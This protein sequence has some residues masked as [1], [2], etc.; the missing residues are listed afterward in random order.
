MK[1]KMYSLKERFKV[2]V[3]DTILVNGYVDR[4]DNVPEIDPGY[5][6][7]PNVLRDIY[8]WWVSGTNDGFFVF[9]PHGC[10]KT[11]ALTQFFARLNVPVYEKTLY[12]KLRF[13]DLV[14]SFQLVNGNTILYYGPLCKAMGVED[15][16]GVFLMNECD[17][18]N[19]GVLTGM[20][21]IMQGGPLDVLGHETLKPMPGFRIA[22]TANTGMLL[23]DTSGVYPG[24]KRQS[25]AFVDRFWQI[26]ATYPSKETEIK[27]LEKK[28]PGLPA[29]IRDK[30]IDVA[31]DI[32]GSFIG[33][34]N[35]ADAREVTISTRALIRWASMA[36]IYK[37][38]EARGV[39]P[40][41]YSL[42]RAVLNVASEETRA[43]IHQVVHA[44]FDIKKGANTA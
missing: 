21:E 11:T 35:R 34:S 22:A 42:D 26:K 30:M 8:N 12:E 14:G 6:H 16:P 7:D 23:G 39:N 36:L 3:P 1:E 28:V 29:K 37:D 18:S 43:A 17:R 9:G 32:R 20:Y 25:A 44:S 33:T 38:A 4:T 19:P 40:I 10:G 27:V 31:N 41:L 15:A 2:N 5:E 13:E 24:A